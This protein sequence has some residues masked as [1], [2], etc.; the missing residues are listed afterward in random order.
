MLNQVDVDRK[1]EALSLELRELDDN[2]R[3][4]LY[5]LAQ[6]K[7]KD[8]DTYAALNWF[9]VTGIHHFYLGR[10]LAGAIDL[11]LFCIAILLIVAGYLQFGVLLIIAVSLVELWALFR[12][13]IIVQDFNNRV[14]ETLLQQFKPR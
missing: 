13:Q 1:E 7:I 6:K 3:A 5:A 2:T 10:W 11:G 12:S 4:E 9:F 8:P 14:Y